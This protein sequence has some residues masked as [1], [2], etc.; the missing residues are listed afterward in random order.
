MSIK[1]LIAQGESRTLE[2]KSSLQWD[3]HQQKQNTALRQN[4]LKTIAAF[5][6]TDGGTLIIGVDDQGNILGI[7][8][9]L[10]L[11][12]HSRD[13]FEQ[14]F[15]SLISDHLGAQYAPLIRGRFEDVEGKV[16]YVVV[17][18]PASEPVFLKGSRGEEFYVRVETTTRNLNPKETVEY[19]KIHWPALK[20]VHKAM[21]IKIEA[22]GGF[23]RAFYTITIPH[24]DILEGRL[25]MDVF[26]ADLWEVFK[27]RAPDEYQDPER[28]FRKTYPT[29]GLTNLLAVVEKRLRGQ[30]GDPVI[31][32]Q[33]PFGGGKTHALIA[34]YHK[35]RE[36]QARTV[37]F[38][39]T[40]V[41]AR[42][43]TP[44]GL[45][46]EQL[47]GSRAGF[48]APISPGGEA[49]RGLLAAHQ[50]VLILMDEVLEYATKAAGV[51]VGQTNLAAQTQAF[52][53]ELTETVRTLEK[54]CLVLTL[55]SK[56]LEQY[57]ENAQRLFHQMQKVVGRMK[58]T[59]T[60]VQEHEI[61]PVIR[62]RLFHRVDEAA[63]R[64]VVDAFLR[65]AEQE[66]LLPPGVEPSV[67]RDRFLASYPFLPEVID[68]LYHRWGSFI[69]FQRTRGVLRLLG[70][71]VH[72]LKER[73]LPYITLADFDL[74]D[75]EI[76]QELLEHIGQEYDSVIAADITDTAAGAR[77]VDQELGDTY[78]W[79][80]LG[81]RVATT[82]FM[83]SFS[84]GVERGA[85]LGQVKRHAALLQYPASAV[86]E[87]LAHLKTKLFYLQQSDGKVYFSNQPNL[88]HILLV[89]EENVR[90]EDISRLEQERLNDHVR[91]QK[92]KVYL[93]PES[94]NDIPDTPELKLLIFRQR[95]QARMRRFLEKKGMTPRVHRNTLFFLAPMEHE[96][97]AL[98]RLLRQYAALRSIERDTSLRLTAEQ[99]KEVKERAKQLE[100]D[101]TEQIRSAYRLIYIPAKGGDLRELDMGVGTYGMDLPIDEE[102]YEKLRTEGEILERLQPLVLK[103]R[104]LRDQD[105]IHTEQLVHSWSQT[106]GALRVVSEEAWRRCI[107]EGVQQGLF[108]LGV[109]EDGEIRCRAYKESPMV[110][111][112]G[113]ESL[114]RADICEAQRSQSTPD[115]SQQGGAWPGPQPP[116][117]HVGDNAEEVRTIEQEG[118]SYS[119]AGT[120][121]RSI[122]FRFVVP[123]GQ[124]ASLL[125]IFNLLQHRFN[126]LEVTLNASE[127]EMSEEEIEFKI[128]EAFRQ[129][130]IE[131]EDLG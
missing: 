78:R 76:R 40:K 101:L 67:Y 39:G 123:K 113:N 85:T 35:A 124:V 74:T 79:L 4:V 42:K 14:L 94:E 5:L 91:R 6:N 116:S 73:Y 37:V 49:M 55:A 31:Q 72:N 92:L 64:E 15:A 81:T 118:P 18:Q 88:N 3:V 47:T 52:L 95:D 96:H 23:A 128:K 34:M 130:G 2:F 33:T 20:D 127:G 98:Q 71:V 10:A 84:G 8:P 63:A 26:A 109:L 24:D 105:Y 53:Q 70:L 65:Y 36:W 62:R 1:A 44:W 119:P 100:R 107:V 17:V 43:D 99:R 110:A 41:D 59:Y 30:D 51:T 90:P 120:V 56:P 12:K 122:H 86:A 9:D 129:M 104:Y 115:E 25:T 27:G 46:A 102:V 45:M 7:E 54:V 38:V 114:I 89:R 108:G 111:L 121:R 80:R 66:N 69:T 77:K 58:K 68:V 131:P 11:V 106:P 87:A 82:I 50:P 97:L 126:R 103:E 75:Q 112:V 61:S 32:L 28:F 22:A 29:E 83:H 117:I 21:G 19:I 57:D 48:E 60:P 16:V 93:W 125:W 13:R